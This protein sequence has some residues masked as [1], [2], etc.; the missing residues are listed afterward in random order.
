MKMDMIDEKEGKVGCRL[1]QCAI[2]NN[3]ESF[4]IGNGTLTARKV[5]IV[6]SPPGAYRSIISPKG[7]VTAT[8][9]PICHPQRLV[10]KLF[11]A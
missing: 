2:F 10:S 3:S 5:A 6:P 7:K 4:K 9:T 8:K 11:H 1:S